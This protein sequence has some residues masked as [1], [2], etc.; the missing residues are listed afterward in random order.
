MNE[1]SKHLLTCYGS[2]GMESKNRQ[3]IG[4]KK[5]E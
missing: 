2:I 1:F 3:K 4:M 5:I